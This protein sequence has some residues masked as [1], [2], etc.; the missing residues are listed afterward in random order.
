MILY[1]LL[2]TLILL[3]SACQTNP[4]T[5]PPV[6]PEKT[7]KLVAY[8][9][10]FSGP[11][12]GS[13]AYY[14]LAAKEGIELAVEEINRAGGINGAPLEIIYEDDRNNTADAQTVLLKLARSD[15]VP[16]IIGINS[17]SVTLATCKKAA[18]SEVVQYSIGSS[19]KIGPQCGDFTFQLQ[20]NDL[21]Q[22]AELAATAAPEDQGAAVVYINNDYG[23]GNKVSFVEN[24]RQ[25]GIQMLA[26]VPLLPGSESFQTE[27][28]QVIEANPELIALIAYGTEGA[29]F[30]HQ[31]TASGLKT[32]FVGDT[33]W[34]DPTAWDLAGEALIGMISLRAGARSSPAYQEYE[35]AFQKRYGKPP[36]IWSEYFYDEVYLAAQAIQQGGYSGSGIRDATRRICQTFTGASGPK[37]LDAENTPVGV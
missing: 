7:T 24:A 13:G 21:E 1:T 12:S 11:L 5:V 17:S 3:V 22:G 6:L 20:G 16:L 26:E 30:L 9:I 29:A 18:E 23:I 4:K 19:P 33:N 35:A 32:Q 36:S 28:Q 10:G 34:G 27:V 2:L 15:Q 8:K 31:A 14:G 37:K 25:T